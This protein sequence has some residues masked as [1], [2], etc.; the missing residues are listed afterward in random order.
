MNDMN[1]V[2]AL[3]VKY[4]H[5][6]V[7]LSGVL[8]DIEAVAEGVGKDLGF[9]HLCFTHIDKDYAPVNKRVNDLID[10]KKQGLVVC[11][12]AF[13]QDELDFRVDVHIHLSVTKTMAAEF[14]KSLD[15]DKY[16]ESL[17]TNRIN[18][19]INVKPGYDIEKIGDAVFDFV[20]SNIDSKVHPKKEYKD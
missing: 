1:I 6:V 2:D 5:Y 8:S 19:Y 13:P 17:K 18:K 4:P 16:I 10:K 14:D 7:L 3:F 9:T 15:Y 20:I 12:P 11:G